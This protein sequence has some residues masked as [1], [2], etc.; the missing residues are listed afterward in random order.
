MNKKL[1]NAPHFKA[2][3]EKVSNFSDWFIF[4]GDEAFQG[5]D[6]SNGTDYLNLMDHVFKIPNNKRTP[7]VILGNKQLTELQGL[8]IAP[9]E[10]RYIKLF[11]IGALSESQKTA[12]CL[13]LAQYTAVTKC[14]LYD[15]TGGFIESLGDYIERVRTGDTAAEIVAETVGNGLQVTLTADEMRNAPVNK[16]TAYFLQWL[17]TQPINNKLAYH[18]LH[19]RLYCFNGKTWDYLPDT[20]AH[21]LIKD[22]FN[23]YGVGHSMQKVKNICEYLSVELPFFGETAPH[24]LAFNNGVLNKDT[25]EFLPHNPDYWLIGFNECDYSD[26]PPPT[27]HFDK[28]LDFISSGNEQ[29]KLGFLAGLYMILFN[30]NDWQLTLELIGEAGGGKSVF[31]EVGKMLAGSNNSEPISLKALNDERQIVKILNKSFIYSSDES[32]Y[33]GDSSIFKKLSSGE[34]VD[35]NPK[36]KPAFSVAVKAI[37]ALASNTL[38]IYK[39]D[40]GGMDRRRVIFPFYRAVTPE[41]RDPQ[42]ISKLQG[43]LAG[44]VRKIITTFPIADGAKLALYE[45]QRNDEVLKLKRDNDH[46]LDF[47]QAF[48]LLDRASNKGLVYGG[49]N[50]VPTN[51]LLMLDKFYWAYL[52]YCE[53]H[54]IDDRQRLKPKYLEQELKH[55]FKSAGYSINFHINTLGGR[56]RHTNAIYKDKEGTYKQW[57]N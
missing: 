28:W 26:N 53:A 3:A 34:A 49:L 55:A 2:Q 46:I 48:E 30:R 21:R 56:Q 5:Y 24:F 52:F 32:K 14:E 40:G 47:I 57:T 1:K 39:N 41:Q 27:P 38:P 31:L 9:T 37:F 8:Q 36:N 45:Q 12:I 17:S 16:I 7:P 10:Q 42:L 6:K 43:E 11:Q 13:N 4:V 44:I 23:A 35:F 50:S 15:R 51:P 22:F 18:A 20:H 19:N 25:L 33:I 54:G 29:R